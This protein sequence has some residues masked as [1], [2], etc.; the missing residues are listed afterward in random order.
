MWYYGEHNRLIRERNKREK[1]AWNCVVCVAESVAL[2]MCDLMSRV[3]GAALC[4]ILG[5][6]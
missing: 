3:A 5:S 2:G 6:L 1:V 4:R